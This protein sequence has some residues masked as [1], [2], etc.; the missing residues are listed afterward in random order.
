MLWRKKLSLLLVICVS[1][2][3]LWHIGLV[4]AARHLQGL[5]GSTSGSSSILGSSSELGTSLGVASAGSGNSGGSSGSLLQAV[6]SGSINSSP[7]PGTLGLAGLSSPPPANAMPQ[8]N[9]NPSQ[10][11]FNSGTGRRMHAH[12]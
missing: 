5:P 7:P 3:L 2:L 11:S 8:L 10:S 12:A 6:Q 9:Y 1:S 4:E